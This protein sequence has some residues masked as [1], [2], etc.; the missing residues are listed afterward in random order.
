MMESDLDLPAVRNASFEAGDQQFHLSVV[1]PTIWRDSLSNAVASALALDCTR[2]RVEVIVVVDRED[3]SDTEHEAPLKIDPRARVYHTGGRR[4]AS[5]ARN[6]G[7]EVATAKF[8]AF[9]DDDD[10]YLPQK[11]GESAVN[12]IEEN[13]PRTILTGRAWY[14]LRGN[15]DVLVPRVCYSSGDVADY[16]FVRRRLSAARNLIPTPTWIMSRDFAAEVKWSEG[17]SRHQDWDFII[18]AQKMHGAKIVQIEEAVVV[19]NMESQA[20]ITSAGGDNR[21][22]DW[23]CQ[24]K[25]LVSKQA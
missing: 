11:M 1:I 2:Y 12:F 7:I 3:R 16:L 24:M 21:S 9:L 20:S 14:R 8:I 19:V 18:R 10:E 17:R 4:G 22:F 23:I 5:H 6:L 13:R 25:D 15:P